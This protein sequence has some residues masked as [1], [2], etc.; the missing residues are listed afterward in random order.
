M[1]PR[2]LFDYWKSI[3]EEHRV[4]YITVYAYR[5]IPVLDVTQPLSAEQL[6]EIRKK[7][8]P[9]PSINIGKLYDPIDPEAWADFCIDT[10]GAGDYHFK[11]NNTHP[12]VKKTI[13]M[14]TTSP[15]DDPRFREWDNY[16]PVLK[17]DEVVLAEKENQPYLRWARMK[18]FRFPGDPDQPTEVETPKDTEDMASQN[19][20]ISKLTDTVVRMAENAASARPQP[21]PI[22]T[23]R[24]A[25][26]EA[27]LETA[28]LVASGGKMALDIVTDAMRSQAAANLKAADPTEHFNKVME[29]AERIAPKQTGPSLV[30]LMTMMNQMTATQASQTNAMI[31]AM[32]ASNLATQQQ[33]AARLELAEK[34]N[35]ELMN[36][37][38][39]RQNPPPAAAAP[40]S[41]VSSLKE[42]LEVV[43]LFRNGTESLAGESAGAPTTW[44]DVVAEMLPKALDT[45]Q[46]VA[47]AYMSR[48]NPS[49]GL[50][51]NAQPAMPGGAPAIPQQTQQPRDAEMDMVVLILKPLLSQ[52]VAS[53]LPGNIFA[54]QL[55]AKFGEDAYN[56]ATAGGEAGLMALVQK[57]GELLAL[58]QRAGQQFISDFLNRELVIQTL[59]QAAQQQ[60]Q[61]QVVHRPPPAGRPA[62]PPPSQQV[63]D[64]QQPGAAPAQGRVIHRGDGSSVVTAKPNGQV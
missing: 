52:A 24:D 58:A 17:L 40:A 62:G 33:L 7:H 50:Q 46:T 59:Q 60:A 29:L 64:A 13:C 12:S 35:H 34:Q 1:T 16:P 37:L 56:R 39:D 30:E 36:K 19:E 20:S 28:K 9:K 4:N 14:A 25:A 53:N 10:W 48:P 54:A 26:S 18:G 3:P 15:K 57:D 43:K 41:P 23:R 45:V 38:L 61:P 21:V 22:D 8:K 5:T 44:T 63:V 49:P 6:E 27:S 31:A 2:E 55:V 11:L 42:V 47:G 32:Q 51:P